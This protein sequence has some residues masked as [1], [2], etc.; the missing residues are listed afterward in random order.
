M[1]ITIDIDCGKHR[2]EVLRPAI[3]AIVAD[4]VKSRLVESG[5]TVKG[6]FCD[7]GIDEGK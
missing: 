3:V 5:A 7:I 6:V 2:P 4:V 1:R